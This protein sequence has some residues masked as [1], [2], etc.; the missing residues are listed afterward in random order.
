MT[1]PTILV[2]L[3][4]CTGCWTCSLAC[5]AGYNLPEDE[6]WQ[7]IRTVGSGSGVDEPAGTWPNLKM[8]W[9]PVYSQ[10]CLLCGERTEQG[11]EPFCTY[12]CP[13]NALVYGDLD[14]PTSE[15]AIQLEKAREKGY[16]V[17]QMKS[18]E[19]TR[20]EIYYAEK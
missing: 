12:N 13:T 15:V 9:V 14:D 8:K 20:P 19:R 18:W 17:F 16:R 10:D 7:Y 11:L 5:K 2:N 3:N 6:W 4:L 1:Q